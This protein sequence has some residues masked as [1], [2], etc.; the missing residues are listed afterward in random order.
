MN[1][2]KVLNEITLFIDEHLDDEINY[3]LLSK[4]MG[5]NEYIL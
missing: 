2:Y 4:K 3:N 1:I 5:V